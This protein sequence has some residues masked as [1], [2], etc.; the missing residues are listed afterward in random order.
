MIKDKITEYNIYFSMFFSN[1]KSVERTD[2][3]MS[4]ALTDLKRL[5]LLPIVSYRSILSP[6][7][8]HGYP[9]PHPKLTLTCRDE[10][11]AGGRVGPTEN[12][13]VVGPSKTAMSR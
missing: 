7:G 3:P 11:V 1:L 5:N 6:D 13:G 8:C 12:P 4:R 2:Q 10:N 9:R